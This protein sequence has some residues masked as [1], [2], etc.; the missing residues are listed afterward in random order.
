MNAFKYAKDYAMHLNPTINTIHVYHPSPF[1][2]NNQKDSYEDLL[3]DERDK[4]KE[5][6]DQL[7]ELLRS[8]SSVVPITSEFKEGRTADILSDITKASSHELLL[9]G[10]HKGNPLLKKWLCSV[11]LEMIKNSASALRLIPPNAQS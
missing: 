8:N 1:Y 2:D 11:S 6:C 10:T 3:K 9:M 4:F 7:E 5:H